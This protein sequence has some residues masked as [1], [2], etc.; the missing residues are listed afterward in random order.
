[1]SKIFQSAMDVAERQL[2]NDA[3]YGGISKQIVKSTH[4]RFEQHNVKA[5]NSTI[6]LLSACISEMCGIMLNATMQQM[7]QRT[8]TIDMV[9]NKCTVHTLSNG[10]KCVNSSMLRLLH[11]LRLPH[12]LIQSK[13]EDT[14]RKRKQPE[15]GAREPNKL[16]E[17]QVSF[18]QDVVKS[19]KTRPSTPDNCFWD[20][21]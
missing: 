20:E 17:K 7:D 12:P 19:K 14:S 3:K 2:Q 5:S 15:S 13:K 6:V 8:M 9:T 18:H 10:D 11:V 4:S 16:E 21:D 1:M